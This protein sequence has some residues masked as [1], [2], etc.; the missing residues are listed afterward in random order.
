M[1][2][3]HMKVVAGMAISAFSV[4][5]ATDAVAGATPPVDTTAKVLS[6]QSADGKDYVVTEITIAPGGSTGW[7]THQGEVYG[8]VKQG[9]LTHYGSDCRHDGQYGGGQPITDPSGADHVHN[10]RNLGA[11]PVVLDV[12]YVDPAGAP[13]SDSAPNPGCNFE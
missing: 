11:T 10:A 4:S 5:A 9:V 2:Q 1:K 7:H 8:L 3:W 6:R 13:T 12:T